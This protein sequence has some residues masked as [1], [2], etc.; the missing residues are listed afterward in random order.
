M[1]F[2]AKKE[3]PPP[4]KV[5][6]EGITAAAVRMTL[7]K[8]QW[9]GYKFA[10]E[11][12]Q[13]QAWN[14]YDTNEQLHNATDYIGSACSLVRIYVAH[15]DENGVRQEE[16][17]EDKSVAAL[18]DNLFGGPAG[19]A[20]MLNNIARSLTIAGECYIIGISKYMG[21][22]DKWMVV[23]PTEVRRTGSG[24]SSGPSGAMKGKIYNVQIG[25]GIREDLN[26]DK[27]IIARIWSP[28]PR[29][30]LQADSPVR[31]MLGLLTRMAELEMFLSA[32]LNSRIA[33]ASLLP[34]PSTL[35]FPEGDSE[36]PSKDDIIEQMYEVITANLEGRGTA[37]QVAPILWPMPLPEL[38]LMKGMEPITFSS[39]LSE[40]AIKL[41]AESQQ[42]L[43][44]GINVPVEV[45]IGG[46][47]MNHWGVWFAGEEFIVKSIMPM[48]GRIVDAINTAYLYPALMRMGRDPSKYT[49]WYDVAPLASSANKLIDTLN[50]Y[51][52]GIV[53][54]ETVRQVAAFNASNAPSKMESAQR[55]V[56]E[57][58]LRD[59]TLFSVEQ[60]RELLEI[61]LEIPS[62]DAIGMA[63]AGPPPPPV[64]EELPAGPAP[65][66][67]PLMEDTEG[68]D[69][70][71]ELIAAITP[72]SGTLIAANSA[73]IRTLEL[74]NKRMYK[75]AIREQ[76][77]DADM[78]NLHTKLRILEPSQTDRLLAGAWDYLEDQMEGTGVSAA[79]VQPVLNDYVCGLLLHS[80][81]H[82]RSLLSAALVRAGIC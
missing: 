60:V 51:R 74:A 48:M 39:P 6:P 2:R 26:P 68:L 75:P 32:Q 77:P 82:S 65:G 1:V 41:R 45:Q 31:A 29:K 27:D 47:E 37:A 13:N 46:S 43:A 16:V 35:N 59:P 81:E 76:Y 3:A 4:P 53:S 57:V 8:D 72:A 10:D 9:R 30:P 71:D 18:A 24:A 73:V 56:K 44:I 79:A 50:L 36:S 66:Q 23:G 49:Y 63:E 17:T 5:Q 78:R 62:P 12:W 20:E 14:F 55:Y 54:A 19:K 67:K 11:A 52:E 7:S 64:P 34:V 80:I 33:N 61:F 25:Q 40:E 28:H 15:V 70:G 69:A 22:A 21:G 42:K 58:V 38:E